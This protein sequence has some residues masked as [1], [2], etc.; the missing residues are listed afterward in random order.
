MLYVFYGQIVARLVLPPECL[1]NLFLSDGETSC[2][3]LDQPQPQS[4]GRVQHPVQ[5]VETESPVMAGGYQEIGGKTEGGGG[6]GGRAVGRLV[7]TVLSLVV[8][9]GLLAFTVLSLSSG[10]A[11]EDEVVVLMTSGG[12]WAGLPPPHTPD[13]K[14]DPKPSQS[15]LGR[16]DYAAVAVDSIPC[17][18]IGK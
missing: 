2:C 15:Q 6:G 12:G 7:V 13:P 11:R 17:S 18:K 10:L 3:H 4:C 8:V 16:F 1:L 14:W 9:L 5:S